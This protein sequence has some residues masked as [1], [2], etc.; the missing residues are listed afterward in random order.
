MFFTVKANS[1]GVVFVLLKTGKKY[2]FK[3]ECAVNS[4]EKRNT[5]RTVNEN[6]LCLYWA[7]K[8]FRLV[9]RGL[10]IAGMPKKRFQV[11][12]LG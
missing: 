10:Q 9:V 2:K 5:E 12:E 4:L 11:C 1:P 6:S 8:F 7:G 3:V